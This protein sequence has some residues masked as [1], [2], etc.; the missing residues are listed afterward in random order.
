MT[1]LP[2]AKHPPV[3]SV[4]GSGALLAQFEISV[5]EFEGVVDVP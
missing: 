1:E 2:D 4:V 5:A 3:F